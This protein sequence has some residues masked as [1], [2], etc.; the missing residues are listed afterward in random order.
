MIL[1]DKLKKNKL[2][3]IV[4]LIYAGMFVVMP[5]NAF[6]SVS[7]SVY[8][9]L[10]MLQVLPVIFMLTVI[11]EAWIPK[12]VITRRF[13]NKSGFSGN[14]LSLLLGSFSAGPIYAA[15]PLSKM[16]IAKGA[17]VT[18]IV[19]ILSS[20][21]VVKFPMLII[22]VKFLGT[23]FMAVRWLLTVIAIIIMAYLVSLLVK[24]KDLPGDDALEGVKVIFEVKK[25]YCNGCG[26]CVKMFP[27]FYEMRSNKAQTKII[28]D[29]KGSLAA[30]KVSA[31]QCPSK[32]IVLLP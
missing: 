4:G 8:Y 30:V 20:W 26:L 11:I 29:M 7:N 23:H 15:F 31:E 2:I 19:I 17:S 25:Q 32:A 18:N 1:A 21:A 24:S 16:L 10:E 3:F 9:L 27:D 22:E 6:K 14:L 5:E 12:E 28:P 13:G